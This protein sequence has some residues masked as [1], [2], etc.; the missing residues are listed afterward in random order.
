[1]NAFNRITSAIFDLILDLPP[2]DQHAWFDMIVWPVLGGIVALLV[3][4]YTSNQAGI[5]HAKGQIK[6]RL[7]EIRL[8]SHDIGM[9]VRATGHIL[10]NNGKYL[11]LN[12]VPM[13]VMIV[14]IMSM[15][16]Q[17]EARYAFDPMPV[18][19]EELLELELDPEHNTVPVTDVR[20]ELPAGVAQ[21][22][23]PVRTPDGQVFWRLRAEAAGD[24]VLRIH[25]GETVVEKGLAVGGEPRKVPVMRTKSLDALLY[26]GEAGLPTDSPVYDVRVRYPERELAY[27]PDGELGILVFFFVISLVS[28]YA[29]KDVFGVVL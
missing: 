2:G 13:L 4:K 19:H 24:H 6:M 10:W 23:P 15:L 17:L 8:F 20:L 14:P 12:V 11:G 29:L 9:V 28:G 16:V 5:T 18:G 3:Y 22:G 27:L 1:M 7:V 25:V 21:L 26:P